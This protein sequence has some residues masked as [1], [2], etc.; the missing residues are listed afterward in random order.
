MPE[1]LDLLE[2]TSRTFALSIPLLPDP[3]REEV[4]VAYL[5]FRIA[6]TFEDA[7]AWPQERRIRAL[8]EFRRLVSEPD[9]QEAAR[10]AATWAAEVPVDHDG[11]RQLLGETPFVLERFAALGDGGRSTIRLHTTRTVRGMAEIVGRTDPDGVLRLDDLEDLRDYCYI[12]AGIVGEMLTEL[13]LERR[14]GLRPVASYLRDRSAKFGEGLQLVNILKDAATDADEGRLYL[15]RELS[16]AA[17]LDLARRDLE[18]AAE[19][20]L[21]L[22]NAGAERG[23]VAFNALPIRLA[24]ATLARVEARGPGSKISRSEVW[25]IVESL[26]RALDDGWPA[27]DPPS[28]SHARR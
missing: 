25:E 8:E 22:Q 20:T 6:D 1:L 3:T 7:T 4:T 19:Y 21:A 24:W 10:L 12:V 11:Y 14:D 5:L 2:K 9:A 16:R 27:V 17:V 18:A 15:P 23:L 13:F 28:A 26:E